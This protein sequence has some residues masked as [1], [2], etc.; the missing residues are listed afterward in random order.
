M[1]LALSLAPIVRALGGDLYAGGRRANI[2][3][4]GHS[5]ADRSVSLLLV[6]RR[7]LVHTFAGQDWREVLDDLRARGLVDG[8]GDLAG[9]GAARP[10]TVEPAVLGRP[11]R[12][13]VARR[14]WLEARPIRGTLA[15]RY[16]RSRAIAGPLP[17]ALRHHPAV[18]AATYAD[19]GPRRP[20]LLA[21]IC[22]PDGAF[23][24]VEV[25]FLAPGGSRARM[26][27][28]RKTLGGCPAGSAIRLGPAGARLVV[29]EGVF[30]ALSAAVV[31]GAPAWALMSTRNLRGWR[32]PP[33]VRE[34]VIAADRG[35]DGERSARILAAGLRAA[36]VH[37]TVRWPRAPFGDWN[38]AAMASAAAGGGGRAG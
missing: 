16:C 32:P 20:A 3:G 25:T 2:P 21:A 35:G 17:P 4:P 15:E 36:G 24:G 7:V 30:T 1:T 38:E 29:G 33:G 19:A 23:A 8:A 12:L 34:V 10:S 9:A 37:G 26:P 31:H 13:A 27:L 18:A 14:L 22:G 6:G 28:A 11:A 5:R